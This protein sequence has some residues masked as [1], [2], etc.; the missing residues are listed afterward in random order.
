MA[1]GLAQFIRAKERF[2]RCHHREIHLRLLNR[3]LFNI[4]KL[5]LS[6]ECVVTINKSKLRTFSRNAFIFIKLPEPPPAGT[7]EKLP[8]NG[9]YLPAALEAGLAA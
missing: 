5:S 4:H 9:R 6:F 2:R 3:C 1:S 7:A 8:L